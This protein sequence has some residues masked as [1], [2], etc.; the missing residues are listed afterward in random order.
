MVTKTRNVTKVIHSLKVGDTVIKSQEQITYHV[1]NHLKILFDNVYVL[2][3]NSLVEDVIP[4]LVTDQ[5]NNMLI[6]MPI[7]SNYVMNRLTIEDSG[8]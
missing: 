1:V 3:D 5:T 6:M 4:K 2:Q 7:E 8:R